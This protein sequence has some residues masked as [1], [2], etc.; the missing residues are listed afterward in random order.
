MLTSHLVA[1]TF[2]EALRKQ[3]PELDLY[4]LIRLSMAQRSM[5]FE[6]FLQEADCQFQRMLEAEARGEF[7][8][9]DEFKRGDTRQWV[10]AGIRDLGIFHDA[11]VIKVVDGVV[12]TEDMNLLYYYRNRLSGYGL[13]LLAAG[14]GR[15]IRGQ[16]DRKGFLA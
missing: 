12:H 4:R 2:F 8:L 9:S 15:R 10:E 11:A 14:E 13:S 3:Y 7:Y 16:N 5:P 6:K 1:F